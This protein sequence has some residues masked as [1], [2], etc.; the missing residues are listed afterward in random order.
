MEHFSQASGIEDTVQ[1][2][3]LEQNTIVI[4]LGEVFRI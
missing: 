4:S 1:L 3:E 2:S